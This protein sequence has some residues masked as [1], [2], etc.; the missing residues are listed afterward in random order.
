MDL[1]IA[2]GTIYPGGADPFIGD[3]AVRGERIVALG[4]RLSVNAARTI[5]ARGMI[6]APGFIDPHTHM[7][8]WL[9]SEEPRTRLVE[10]F[11][12]QGVTTAVIGSDGRGPVEMDNLLAGASGRPPGINFAAFTGFGTIRQQVIGN[13]RRAPLP[14]ELERERTLVR[15]A[16]CE[17]AL[18]LSTGLFYAPQS[19]SEKPEVVALAHV[20]G[21]LGG[22]YD[23]HL[24]DESNY[25]VGLTAAVDETIA[26]AREAGIPVHIS[27]IK[28][29]G[30]DLHGMA[31]SI[32]ARI[33]KA[34]AEGL[35]VTANQYPWEAS[36]T[37]MVA[38]LVPL[39]AQAGGRPAMLA[40]LGDPVVR[41]GMADNL[42]RRG[43][44]D[45]LLVVEGPWKGRRLS[46]IAIATGT[47]PLAAATAIIRE[48]DVS[49][50]S[51]N[52]AES[53]IATFMRQPWTMT[54]SDASGGHP[55][56]YGSFA[57]K[58]AVYAKERRVI[59]TREFVDRSTAVTA[60]FLGLKERGRLKPG[61]FADIAVFDPA[62]FAAGATYEEPQLVASGMRTVVVNG[63]LAVDAGSLTGAAAGK[64]LRR[65]P[66]P[67]RCPA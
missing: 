20:A 15:K 9:T 30:V 41:E 46:E 14:D 51:F 3:L 49:V 26:I 2:G 65:T 28:A 4:P 61:H 21:E 57:R 47:D 6:V 42:R 44:P 59:S 36:G 18:G 64:A 35:D 22:V 45:S 7:D 56:M 17:G 60:D 48:A 10:P 67:G 50:V 8:G 1:L 58:F 63:Q 43:G 37:S 33:E 40:R 38:S 25:T 66:P 31:P 55:R 54:G 34:R 24:R 62:T 52:M 29:L 23:T 32:V 39:A 12:M 53:D 19:F 11:L 16:M 5:D 27:H 13:A